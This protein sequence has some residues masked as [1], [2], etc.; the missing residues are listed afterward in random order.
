MHKQ[1]LP[2]ALLAVCP[3]VEQPQ[4]TSGQQTK[5]KERDDCPAVE[6]PQQT[7]GQQNKQKEREHDLQDAM[8]TLLMLAHP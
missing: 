6:Q 3:A 5:Q 1:K 4:Q 2:A 8:A 7:S